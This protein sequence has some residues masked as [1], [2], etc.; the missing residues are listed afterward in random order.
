M[1]ENDDDVFDLSEEM[2]N[3]GFKSPLEQFI[4][5][6]PYWLFL[7]DWGII[8]GGASRVVAAVEII[9]CFRRNQFPPIG[10]N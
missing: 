3:K 4:K 9:E 8:N 2:K 10:K 5:Q 7:Y 1:T 6:N